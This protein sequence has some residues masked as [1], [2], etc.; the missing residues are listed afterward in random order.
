MDAMQQKWK[1]RVGLSGPMRKRVG[2]E[3]VRVAPHEYV[4]VDPAG[5]PP[6]AVLAVWQKTSSGTYQAVPMTD[7]ML[8]LTSKLA[9]V[10]GFAGSYDTLHRLGRSGFIE[11][12]KVAPHTTLLNVD[13]Y[14][15]HLRRC[16][17]DPYF[18]EAENN[19]NEYVKAI[20]MYGED[21]EEGA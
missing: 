17:E 20:R 9:A 14:Y 10:L 13:S 11:I 15:R 5:Q 12:V 4:P 19:Y 6:D 1:Q 21:A 8:R 2:S 18:W 16:A 3:M 7:R